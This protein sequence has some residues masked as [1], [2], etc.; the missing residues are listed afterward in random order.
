MESPSP[1]AVPSRSRIL[2]R[3]LNHWLPR[4][5]QEETKSCFAR[6]KRGDSLFCTTRL[7]QWWLFRRHEYIKSP[8]HPVKQKEDGYEYGKVE[9]V[10]F[11]MLLSSS[12]HVLVPPSVTRRG[13][14]TKAIPH[15]VRQ[16]VPSNRG[17]S[18]YPMAGDS[19]TW[20]WSSWCTAGFHVE[21]SQSE[22]QKRQLLPPRKTT[23]HQQ[24]KFPKVKEKNRQVYVTNQKEAV[25]GKEACAAAWSCSVMSML[26]SLSHGRHERTEWLERTEAGAQKSR[27]GSYSSRSS[28]IKSRRKKKK[29]PTGRK[30]KEV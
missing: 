18:P 4:E 23:W 26:L 6:W 21:S 19:W 5:Y 17:R 11:C 14:K 7:E 8:V 3:M 25:E 24:Q 16:G 27:L 28:S 2:K 29:T 12:T 1:A 30:K 9:D 20:S 22:K 15:R 10:V 13:S